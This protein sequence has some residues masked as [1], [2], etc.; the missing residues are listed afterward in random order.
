MNDMRPFADD[1]R[2]LFTFAG[3]GAFLAMAAN[4]LDVILGFGDTSVY[5]YGTRTALE[6]FNVFQ[7]SSFKGVYMLGILNIVYMTCMVPVYFGMVVAHHRTHFVSSVTVVV[8][9]LLAF[10]VYV[11]S[12]AAIPMFVLSGK[13][14][15][16]TTEA[17]KSIFISAAESA[18]ARGEDFTPGSFFG[19]LTGGIAAISMSVIMLRGG[20]FSKTN[21]WIGI[22]GFTFLLVFTF[23]STFI[24]AWYLIVF[25]FFGMFGGLLA[26]AWFVLTGTRFFKLSRQ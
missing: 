24:H 26:L 8:M 2:R 23:V 25:Y 12:S 3:I 16:A 18:L 20:V 9:A 13:Y 1:N 14:A 19:L 21:A 5:V 22:I 10:A 17:Q 4:L 15:A 6:W 7:L 11:S